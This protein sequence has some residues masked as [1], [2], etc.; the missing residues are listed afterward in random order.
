[1]NEVL[2]TIKQNT[3]TPF[4]NASSGI[5]LKVLKPFKEGDFIK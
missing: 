1:M 5:L 4:F 2:Q 3:L